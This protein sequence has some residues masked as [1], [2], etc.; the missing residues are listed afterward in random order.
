MTEH[1][2]QRLHGAAGSG[3]CLWL[4]GLSGAGKSTI[5]RHLADRLEQWQLQP[6]LLDGDAIRASTSRDLGFSQ[7]DRNTNVRRVACLARDVVTAQRPAIVALISPYRATREE[8][9]DIVGRDRFLEIFISTPLTVCE[10]RDVK[11]LYARARRGEITGFTGID[12]PYE[13]PTNPALVIDGSGGSVE[14]ST[15]RIVQLLI[16]GGFAPARRQAV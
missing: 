12:D 8:A 2:S 3:V 10:A 4:T 15:A 16:D 7:S 9:R 14:E 1:T 6:A 11:G 13:P 5:G